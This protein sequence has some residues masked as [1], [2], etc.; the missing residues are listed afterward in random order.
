MSERLEVTRLMAWVKDTTF[1]P[2]QTATLSGEELEKAQIRYTK[3][4]LVICAI[5]RI[6]TEGT[7]YYAIKNLTNT[8]TIWDTLRRRCQPK[9][10][11]Y[12]TSSLRRF[13]AFTLNQYLDPNEYCNEF[14]DRFNELQNFQGTIIID[15]NVLIWIFYKG[16]GPEYKAYVNIY[17]NEYKFFVITTTNNIIVTAPKYN[18]TYAVD[19]FL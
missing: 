6:K 13:S 11:G 4:H 12:L 10:L 16:L 5:I 17:N 18:I 7:S 1:L 15:N 14:Q 3:G 19:R 8:K 2:V 9:G